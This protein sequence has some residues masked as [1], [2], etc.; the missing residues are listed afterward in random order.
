M[1]EF[2]L[3][4]I[5]SNRIRVEKGKVGNKELKEGGGVGWIEKRFFRKSYI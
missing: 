3:R 1:F 2:R 4:W 5:N